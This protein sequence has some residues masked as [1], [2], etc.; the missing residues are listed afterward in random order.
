MRAWTQGTYRVEEE[1]RNLFITLQN[2][3]EVGRQVTAVRA[4]QALKHREE[5]IHVE[6]SAP[7]RALTISKQW[8]VSSGV[9]T[10]KVTSSMHCRSQ[11][12]SKHNS[13]NAQAQAAHSAPQ[14]HTRDRQVQR[15]QTHTH[16]QPKRNQHKRKSNSNRTA[17]IK[18]NNKINKKKEARKRKKQVVSRVSRV[19]SELK[20]VGECASFE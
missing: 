15:K 10:K 12:D 7:P 19:S 5:V 3:A 17:R 16:T 6:V 11:V 9:V 20:A 4:V 8:T 13:N 18:S 14:Q 1:F 2:P